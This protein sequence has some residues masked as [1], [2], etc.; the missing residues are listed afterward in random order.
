MRPSSCKYIGVSPSGLSLQPRP[1]ILDPILPS[2][3][4]HHLRQRQRHAVRPVDL[5]AHLAFLFLDPRLRRATPR[6][7][8]TPPLS[9]APAGPGRH[10]PC[11]VVIRASAVVA[12]QALDPFA[13]D[14][15]LGRLHQFGVKELLLALF[16]HRQFLDALAAVASRRSRAASWAW[17]YASDRTSQRRSVQTYRWPSTSGGQLHVQAEPLG[18]QL[19]GLP[20]DAGTPH[21]LQRLAPVEDR[22]QQRASLGPA[23]LA[24]RQ[25]AEVEILPSRHEGAGGQGR[26]FAVADIGPAAHAEGCCTVLMV[27]I[28]KGSSAVLPGTTAVA[29]GM[30]KGSSTAAAILIW[31]RSGSSLLWPNCNSPCSDRTAA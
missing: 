7:G 5:P 22:L 6:S 24:L 9:C 14:D 2:V 3:R 16:A 1:V 18:H 10:A 20:L 15:R 21:L 31:G 8:R 27:G 30:P 4:P 29:R 13:F 26:H 11:R 28:Y 17:A 19:V 23:E 25:R 12:Q